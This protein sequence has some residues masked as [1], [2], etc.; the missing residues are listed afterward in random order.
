MKLLGIVIALA[1]LMV[2]AITFAQVENCCE[3]ECN[4]CCWEQCCAEQTNMYRVS[5][6]EKV[7]SGFKTPWGATMWAHEWVTVEVEA[8][9]SEEAAE[10]L[11]LRAGYNCFVG[12]AYSIFR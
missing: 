5:Y 7:D 10:M 1:L 9:N 4:S 11:G 6:F 2:P 8:H 12:K 3:Y